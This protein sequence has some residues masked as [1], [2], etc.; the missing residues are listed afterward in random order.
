MKVAVLFSGG[1]DSTYSLYLA[2]AQGREVAVLI[3]IKPFLGSSVLHGTNID[4]TKLQASALGKSIV[5]VG[6][7]STKES[8]L[9]AIKSSL[10]KA[11]EKY[12]IEGVVSGVA[13]SEQQRY[14]LEAICADLGL[15]TIFP[16]W[17]LAPEKYMR[18]QIRLGFDIVFSEVAG[19]GFDRGWLGRKMDNL[20]MEELKKLHA[21]FG[22]SISGEESEYRTL[23][24]DGPNFKKRI[25]VQKVKVEG[26]SL[27]V[28]KARL[29]KK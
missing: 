17:R 16:L 15:K 26:N 14:H 9:K 5:F 22:I 23:V 18:E 2:E 20:A 27:V 8:E 29:V 6:S 13:A 1:K 12:K 11:K 4:I 28:E 10:I 25:E 3:S 21:K 7:G 24:L 19:A